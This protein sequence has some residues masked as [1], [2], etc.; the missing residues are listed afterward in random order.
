VLA[1]INSTLSQKQSIVAKGSY[2]AYFSPDDEHEDVLYI[3]SDEP[4]SADAQHLIQLFCQNALIA[5]QNVLLRD[6]IEGTQ[7]EIVY[8]LGDSIETRSKETGQHVRRVSEYCRLLARG[9]GLS[10]REAEII[11]FAAPLH[12][13]G[14][15]G[16]PDHILHKTGKLDAEEWE[17]MKTH[18]STGRDLLKD[19]KRE[20]LQAAS[21]IAGQHHEKWDGSGYPEALSGEQIHL[22]GRIAA[23]AD[24]FDALGSKRCYKDAWPVEKIVEYLLEQRGR[25]FDPA[26]V[27]WII[28]NLEA[29]VAVRATF[30][31]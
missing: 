24:V 27:D 29:V 22:Y 14:K 16:V 17:I 9:I 6:E 12:D 31:D 11:H 10:E 21:L 18:A 8:L 15:I 2:V 23:I 20:I 4:L 5:Y 28:N 30:P 13:F 7:R 3:S 25:H 26:L 19:S 1:L